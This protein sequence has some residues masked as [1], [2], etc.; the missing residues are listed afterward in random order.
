ME[1]ETIARCFEEIADILDIQ[2]EN[3]FRVRSYRNAARTIAD[4][5]ENVAEIAKAGGDLTRFPGIGTSIAEKIS[6]LARTGRL[7]FL[8]ELKNKLPPGLP[9]L[10]RIEG[11]G[12][13]KVK[14]FHDRLGIEA[15]DQLEAAAREHKLRDL[16]GMGAKSEE[17]ILRA[18]AA[19]RPGAA[20]TRLD[21]GFTYAESIVGRLQGVPGVKQLVPAGSLR[22]RRDTIGDLD[23]L[24]IS[25]DGGPLMEAFAGYDGAE[26]VISRGPTKS[27]LRLRG[28]LQ[29]DLRVLEEKS[30]GAALLYFTGSKDHNIALRRR[31]QERGLKVSEYGIF[32]AG[33]EGKPLAGKTEEECY[34]LLG[35]DW[36][37][38]ELRE[39]RGEIEAAAAGKLP[40]L[41]ELADVRGDL[42]AHTTATDGK[43]SIAEMAAGA[44]AQGYEYLALTDHTRAVR[45]AGGL[46]AAEMSRHLR[47]I[48]KARDGA[49]GIALLK[50]AEVDILADGR[51]DLPDAVLDECDVVVASVHSRFSLP[52]KEMTKRI[53]SA[54]K[55]PRV[56]ILAHPT[57]RL[58]LEREPYAVD[59]EEVI[60]A[61]AGEG[62]ILEINAHPSRLD[63]NDVH[64]RMARAAGAKIVIS[65][66][67]HSVAQFPLMSYGV[68]TARRGWL[69]KGDVVNTYPLAKLRGF[70]KR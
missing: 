11:L 40:D 14:L 34:R 27:S 52:E 37:P 50:G 58:L 35:L 49:K 15:L 68:F 55:N 39:N 57:G 6:E 47:A 46:S 30:F 70:L 48:E 44:Q 10:L 20:R 17:K 3:P 62:V 24:A 21:V 45:V 67:A 33:E 19:Y 9:E 59:I 2:G 23:I 25:S 56:N 26:A 61:A 54:L 22:R 36:I 4:L 12:P 53:V 32:R 13:K 8:E 65:T 51:L 43:N 5:P 60:R 64:A 41:I 16:P 28:G 42:H 29:V 18:I 1:N 63:L 7:N 69:A 66:D 31:A 38:P